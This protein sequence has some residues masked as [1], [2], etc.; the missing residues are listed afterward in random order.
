MNECSPHSRDHN[1]TAFVNSQEVRR[2]CDK[3]Q[4][5]A[6]TGEDAY[7]DQKRTSDPLELELQRSVN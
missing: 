7:G 3:E 1:H 2:N 4:V 6:H 5:P